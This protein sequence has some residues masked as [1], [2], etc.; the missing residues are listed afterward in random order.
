VAS[1]DQTRVRALIEEYAA[2]FQH[3]FYAF[4][5]APERPPA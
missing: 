2:R 4:V 3:D 1:V 5:P